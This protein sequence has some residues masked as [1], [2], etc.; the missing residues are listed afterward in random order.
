MA[1]QNIFHFTD[2]S[3]HADRPWRRVTSSFC[4]EEHKY[5]LQSLW[6]PFYFT[7]Q[8]KKFEQVAVT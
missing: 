3:D 1:L 6:T 8:S 2:D 5:Y 7:D 4:K